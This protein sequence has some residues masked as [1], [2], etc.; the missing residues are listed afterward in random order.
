MA[1]GIGAVAS[2][3][4]MGIGLYQQ[5]QAKIAN[6]K[7]VEAARAQP[8][9]VNPFA[10]QQIPVEAYAAQEQANAQTQANLI[11]AVSQQGAATSIGAVTAIQQQA[12]NANAAITAEKAKDIQQLKSQE[13]GAQMSIDEQYLA[14]QKQLD[15]MEILGSGAA[16]AQGGA[17]TM[18]GLSGLTSVGAVQ[19]GKIKKTK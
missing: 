10:S 6:E 2:L 13:L 12:E 18:A 7:A 3:A 17:M 1:A 19:A 8:K 15:Q 11:N 4:Q 5:N 16:Q 9:Q 14:Y